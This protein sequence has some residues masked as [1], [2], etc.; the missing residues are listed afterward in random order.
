V[1]NFLTLCLVFV[2][3]NI[4]FYCLFRLTDKL[5]ILLK[6]K[7]PFSQDNQKDIICSHLIEGVSYAPLEEYDSS[8]VALS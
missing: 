1:Q 3:I 8:F 6:F 5:L 7:Q 4:A 2:G